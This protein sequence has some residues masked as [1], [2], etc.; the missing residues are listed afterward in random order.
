MADIIYPIEHPEVGH[1]EPGPDVWVVDEPEYTIPHDAEIVFSMVGAETVLTGWLGELVAAS[2]SGATGFALA[3]QGASPNYSL[4]L[5]V[6]GATTAVNPTAATRLYRDITVTPGRS[7][8][9][10]AGLIRSSVGATRTH[11]QIGTA[12]SGTQSGTTGGPA[13]TTAFV[14][15]G[16]TARL[17]AEMYDNPSSSSTVQT[18]WHELK[19]VTVTQEAWI[20]TV[21][22][23]GHFEPGPDVWVVDTPAYTEYVTIPVRD[24]STQEVLYGDRVTTYR[25][26]VLEHSNG[27]DQLVGVLDGVS[28][29]SLRWTQNA[30]VKGSG[31]VSVI[32]LEVAESGK[33][34]IG[35]LPLESLRVRP[36]C[37]IQGLP[38]TPLGV[39]LVSAAVEEWAATGR[40]WSI[41]LLDRCTVPAQDAVEEA[42]AVAAGTLILPTVRTLLASSDEFIAIDESVTLA[43]SS[44]MVWEAGTTK[45]KIINDLLD[46]AGYNSLWMDGF[47]NFKATPRILPADR[48]IIYE[49]L[50]FPRE[51]RDGDLSIYR[52]DWTRDRDSFEVPNKVIAVQAAGGGDAAALT[53]TWTNTDPTSPY[54]YPSRGRWITHVLDSVEC[55]A[56]SNAQIIAFLEKR[57]QTTLIQMSAVQA[58][59]KIEHL[60]IPVRVSDVVRFEHSGAGVD[61]RHVITSLELDTSAQGLMKSTLQEVISL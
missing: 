61:A 27:V 53:G 32:D 9:A 59:V 36:V 1:W 24:L 25:W 15:T 20:E 3:R 58:Q 6:S 46:V 23:E 14:A 8:V 28:D 55:P 29:G 35:E 26:E 51:L 18:P 50:G 47:G 19:D 31:K 56:G 10:S 33:L 60:P 17:S 21:P 54:S 37:S 11:L 7:Y 13:T 48:S 30:A 57:A 34:R 4:R 2:G 41:E 43:T 22:E 42:Y 45:L 38:E 49:V 44:G 5:T 16:A 12:Q 39:F 52:P 40:V